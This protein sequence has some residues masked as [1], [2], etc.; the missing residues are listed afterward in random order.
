MA[1]LGLKIN[2]GLS[3]ALPS[4]TNGNIYVCIDNQKVYA[5]LPS[6]KNETEID[7][8]LLGDTT[9]LSTS[10]ST[11]STQLSSLSNQL[12]DLAK[13]ATSGS[14]N[15]LNNLPR[16]TAPQA[17]TGGA[18][19]YLPFGKFQIDNSSNYGSFIINGRF[20]G[21][22]TGQ[23]ANY[24][25][26]LMNRTGGT[27]GESIY[28]AVSA[29]GDVVNSQSFC[30]LLITKNS[31]KS[32]ILWIKCNTYFTFDFNYC[33]FQHEIIYGNESAIKAAGI[34]P[35]ELK[36]NNITYY[37]LTAE[38][39][40]I[41]W[42]LSEAPKTTLSS[43]GVFTATGGVPAS[44]I[45]GT[46]TKD[47]ISNFPTIPTYTSQLTN[48]SKFVIGDKEYIIKVSTTPPGDGTADNVITFVT[49]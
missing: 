40:N 17:Y 18:I 15:D 6:A 3:T 29:L 4:K 9:S 13:V 32:H 39:S 25:I 12:S 5:D 30:D 11:L 36:H 35:E 7:R 1:D 2:Y 19:W 46:F 38:P 45:T 31:D 34:T 22:I 8:I 14:Y 24:S 33:A 41:I 20:G 37:G 10:I 49:G 44:N 43:T 23:A 42:K 27:T 16:C 48:D 26:M 28:S 21:W 47:I